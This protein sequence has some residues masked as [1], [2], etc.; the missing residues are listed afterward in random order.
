M[1]STPAVP[2]IT[3]TAPTCSSAATNVLST[4]DASLTY[5]STPTGLTVGVGGV[6][7]GGINGTSYTIRAT[8][9]SSCF[10]TSASFT[11]NGSGILS[12]PA[13]PTIT[14]P[15]A[16][17]ASQTGRI[18]ITQVGTDIYSF[19]G[20]AFS[21]TLEYTGLAQG[22]SHTVRAQNA[23]GCISSEAN[24]SIISLLNTWTAG[25]WSLGPPTSEQNIV[26]NSSFTSDADISA[27]SCTVNPGINVVINSLHTLTVTNAV[28]VGNGASLTFKSDTSTPSNSGSLVQENNVTNS[29]N[30]TYERITNT[31]VRN[32]DYT[33]WSSPVGAYTLGDVSQN[34]TKSD[35]YYSY[36]PTASG[37][38]WKQESAATVMGQGIGYAIRGPEAPT[39]APQTPQFYTATFNGVPNNGKITL[40]PIYDGKSYL[41]GNPYPSALDADYFL[42]FNNK[43]LQGTLYFWTHN[44]GL[45]NLG[46]YLSDDYA[47]Y[48]R[49]GGVATKAATS[50]GANNYKP[51]GKIA[52]GQGFFAS[53]NATIVGTKEIVYNNSMRL[54][55][56]TLENNQ[57][58]E[59]NQQFFRT[60]STAKAKTPSV[61]EKHRIWLDLKN[62]QGAFKQM[63]VGYLTGATNNYESRFDGESYDGNDFVDFYSVNQDKNLTIQG[64]VVP[65]DENDT[66][67]LGYKTTIEGSF[68][69]NIDQVD[70]ALTN[71]GVYL[72]DKLTNTVSNLKNG[73]YTFT[74]AKGTFN[75]RFV[76]RYTDKT[77]GLNDT[78]KVD[79]ILVFYSNNYKALIIKNMMDATV[80]SVVLFNTTGQRIANFDIKDSGQTNL[81]IPIKNIASGIYIVKVKTTK[82]ESSKKVIVN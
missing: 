51:S 13:V 17:C 9:T 66:V 21:S 82:G 28:T 7:T 62:S 26:F 58:V 64:R 43:V 3:V 15:P 46:A 12:T 48:N 65:F 55:G 71:Q 52:A 57:T 8:N 53:S 69:I 34:K 32:T 44:T 22:S 67:P 74:T 70:G 38:A 56:T 10:A 68:T 14:T 29:G 75:D 33:Y 80:N 50:V 20:S 81:Q 63:L 4:Y 5:T 16:N 24:I 79:G 31:V 36:E 47:A 60:S 76:L 72:E 1:L 11:Y 40:T 39:G 35:K 73:D 61:L 49:T 23:G 54:A 77:L 37:Q 42:D 78:D 30:I 27:C 2:T 19:D 59:V 18:T 25:V 41:L 45:S 6:I